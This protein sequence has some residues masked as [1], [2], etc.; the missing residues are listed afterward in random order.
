M[1]NKYTTKIDNLIALC[2]IINEYKDFEAKLIIMLSDT[3]NKDF[4]FKLWDVSQGRN[5]FIGKKAKKFYEENKEIIDTINKHTSIYRFTNHNFNS[6]GKP[7]KN[8]EF[9]YN[10]LNKHK[11]HINHIITLLIELKKLGFD[12]FTFD[13]KAIFKEETHIISTN[14]NENN[15]IIYVANP[16]VIPTYANE[17][18]YKSNNSNYKMELV[19]ITNKISLNGRKLTLNSLLFDINTLPLSIDKEHIYDPLLE[20]KKELKR[21]THLI[22]N[23]VNLNISIEDLE[24]QLITTENIINDITNIKTKEELINILINIKK[25]IKSLKSYSLD[26]NNDI[27]NEENSLTTEILEKE[28][29]LYLNRRELSKKYWY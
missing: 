5:I 18:H 22:K 20:T 19:A 24:K 9:Y 7:N 1:K 26:Y 12:E 15:K 29:T 23:S 6:Q 8:M 10:Y 3:K 25:E 16:I 2:H 27:A 21:T 17:I 4:I 14:F 13:E 11:K 28:K